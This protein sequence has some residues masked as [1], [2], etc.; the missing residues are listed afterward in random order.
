[1]VPRY[2]VVGQ[3]G[4]RRVCGLVVQLSGINN[5]PANR[6][7]HRCYP[8]SEP[9]D[10]IIYDLQLE[11]YD[12]FMVCLANVDP[13]TS[14]DSAMR[15]DC[16]KNPLPFARYITPICRPFP[17]YLNSQESYVRTYSIVN[18]KVNHL[19]HD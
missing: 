10:P 2:A 7:E 18:S 4:S 14:N 5:R 1:V 8:Y 19:S 12:M 17:A 13:L 11:N 15:S 3:F 16:L 9:V 6:F